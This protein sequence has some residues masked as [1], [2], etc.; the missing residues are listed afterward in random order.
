LNLA[1]VLEAA[2]FH[3]IEKRAPGRTIIYLKKVKRRRFFVKCCG[4]K[5]CHEGS[6]R[7]RTI[8]AAT[9]IA[10]KEEPQTET[11]VKETI[12]VTT[13]TSTERIG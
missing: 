8:I 7:K 11:P 12:D 13:T 6:Y 10:N 1:I 2:E 5:R 4:A 9:T 3:N